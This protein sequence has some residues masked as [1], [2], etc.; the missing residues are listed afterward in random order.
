MLNEQIFTTYIFIICSQ[1][2]FNLYMLESVRYLF[3]KSLPLMIIANYT[4]QFVRH[5]VRSK[6]EG[7]CENERQEFKQK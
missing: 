6:F 7:N 1:T 4:V 3:N 5:F 2:F